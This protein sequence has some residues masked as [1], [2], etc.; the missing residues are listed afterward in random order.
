MM[1][2]APP[3]RIRT[4]Q[5]AKQFAEGTTACLFNLIIYAHHPD[6]IMSLQVLLEAITERFPCRI[7]FIECDTEAGEKLDVQGFLCSSAEGHL[8]DYEEV[9]LVV[10]LSNLNR[11]PY[12]VLPY[13][14]ADLP[15]FLLW[16]QDPSI[17]KEVLPSLM[18]LANRLIVDSEDTDDFHRF[19]QELLA[20]RKQERL[21]IV[22]LNWARFSG[23]RDALRKV[24]DSTDRLHSLSKANQILI[25]YNQCE[26][27]SKTG[28]LM[29]ALYLQA[30]LAAQFGWKLQKITVEGNARV[31]V[32]R[33]D[34]GEV[35]IKLISETEAKR[36]P[37]MLL[38]VEVSTPNQTE[39]FI[40][41]Q[42]GSRQLMV[43]ISSNEA[44]ELPFTLLLPGVR[45]SYPFLKELF[46][47]PENAH[48]FTMLHLLEQQDWTV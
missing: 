40:K 43:H 13:L 5:D 48:Y 14:L 46:Y 7:I 35:L 34:A 17:E 36:P 39:F 26:G 44:C 30:W 23:W 32:Y 27:I 47:A 10:S 24:F 3:K 41:R 4:L 12:V 18:H 6:Q 11:V 2:E 29:Q 15:V 33:H 9:R 22:D 38:G 28:I 45:R 42:L 1:P 37:G 20:I 16:G 25:R 19:S 21:D 8:P 31:A